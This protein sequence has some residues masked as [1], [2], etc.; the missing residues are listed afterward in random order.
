MSES[1]GAAE[2]SRSDDELL[3]KVGLQNSDQLDP[4]PAEGVPGGW[5]LVTTVVRVARPL[6]RR[7]TD[8]DHRSAGA[9]RGTE[10][11]G[12]SF[13]FEFDCLPGGHCDVTYA[14]DLEE[15]N[16]RAIR[17]DRGGGW[18]TLS[19]SF[20]WSFSVPDEGPS[21]RHK[22]IRYAILEL[23]SKSGVLTG[24]VSVE[25]TSVQSADPVRRRFIALTQ[26]G[27]PFAQSLP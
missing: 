7:L 20:G 12:V 17:L 10:I 27:I 9:P 18:G 22:Y 13:G 23:P 26:G 6:I 21:L 1:T 4:G 3:A 5:G 14:V 2:G 11:F 25:V 24:E 8:G 15:P 16:A 19:P